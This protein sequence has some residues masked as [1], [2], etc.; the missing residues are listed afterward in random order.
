MD[1][2]KEMEVI[3]ENTYQMILKAGV[4]R[5]AELCGYSTAT[6]SEWLRGKTNWSWQKIYKTYKILSQKGE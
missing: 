3:A 4:S 6:V 1:I 5:T 2:E